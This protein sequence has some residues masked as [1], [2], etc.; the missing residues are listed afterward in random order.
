M[1]KL[2]EMKPRSIG[3][4][5]MSGRV[6]AIDAVYDQP[7]II[8]AGTASGGLWKS[9]SGGVGWKPVFD[10]VKSMSIGAVAI[11]QDNPEVVWAGTGE[12]NPRNSLNGGYG[13][14]KSL[15]GG[16]TWDL[17]GLEKTRHIHRIVIHP[18]NPDIVYVGAIG[19]PWGE[20]PER[21]VYKTTDGGKNWKKV[22]YVNEKTGAADLVIDP[23]NPNK[24]FAAMWEH[25]RK[26]WTFHSGGPGSGLYV[27]VDGGENWKKLT[28]EDG[29]PEGDLGR[30]GVA[31]S[32]SNP[33][34]VYALIESKK[35]ALYRS[36]D[37]GYKWQKINDNTNE[38]GNRPFYYSEI[39]VDPQNENRLYTI[40]T[41]V[42]ESEDGGKS[43][44]QLMP[45]YNTSRGVHPDHHAWWI[46]P[47]D[48]SYMIDGNDGGLNITHDRGQTWRFVENLPIAQ[49][50]HINVDMEYPYNVYG[51]M[52]DNGSWAGPAYVWKSQGIR[53]SYWQEISFGDGFDVIPDPDNSRYG[54]SMSQ[55]GFVV[56]YDKETGHQKFMRPTHPDPDMRLRFNWN[57]AIAQDPFDNSTLYF[58]SQFVHKS[59]DKG[60][61]WEVISPDLTTNDPEK[62][63]QDESG[64]LTIDATGAENNTTILAISPSPLQQGVIWVGTDDGFIQ[65]TRDG[66]KSWVNVTP[67]ITGMPK[68]GWVAQ[69]KPSTYN[70]GEAFAVV[71]NYRNSDYKPY[72]FHTTD[73]G[74]TWRS[75]VNESQVWN[76]TLS[77]VQDPV[78][79]KLMFLGSEGGLYVSID[80][81][82]N[83]TQWT[84]GY[85]M[86]PTM[87]LV[88]HPREH[89]L[90]IGTYGRAAYVLDDIRP[91]RA[92]AREGQ[93]VLN[94]QLELFKA[95]DAYLT[96]NQQP[97]GT[98]FSA[99]AIYSGENRKTG[100][101]I[102]YL[103][104][105]PEKKDKPKGEST[106]KKKGKQGNTKLVVEKPSEDSTKVAYD[107]LTLEVFDQ[108]GELLR[109]LK[110]KA[111]K[112]NGAHRMYWRLDEKGVYGPGRTKP[113]KNSPEPGGVSVLPGSYKLK[114]TFGEV[115]DST[116]VNVRFDPRVD[117]S[118]E[119]LKA[120]RAMLKQIE[121][122]QKLAGL[123]TARLVESKK[124]A[125][126]FIKKMNDKDMEAFKEAI[127][128]S[129]AAKD[130]IDALLVP[131]VGEDNSKKQ[132]IIRS[133]IPD[134]G[135]RFGTAS[136]Y[137]QSSLT[138][139]GD[140]EKMLIEQAETKLEVALKEVDSFFETEWENYKQ[141]MEKLDLSP[142]K[143]YEPLQK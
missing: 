108:K 112:E 97:S 130:S 16:K 58:G 94:K 41:Y 114:M 18:D 95:P 4:A 81:G 55:Q 33:K 124:I 61:T 100:A 116:T 121:K 44:T 62:Q 131:F 43:F 105:R 49:F 7:D 123:A 72:L 102:T 42:N 120:R 9:E 59:M 90:V 13:V 92:I 17:M 71:N 98:R 137:I 38:I 21:G 88:I 12:G 23:T 60:D 129:K 86:V 125:D 141:E 82:K 75:M 103:I 79:A 3:P 70:A 11:Q 83:W 139:P 110:R 47:N 142:F 68:A 104:N 109:T 119:V 51:G 1:D 135:D 80:G 140:T 54:Y 10:E 87:D 39:Y 29:L 40:F 66:G 8:Y 53:N 134:I 117:M 6:T 138:A 25:R 22:L 122:G 133:L 24:L 63:K 89:D 46:N 126:D 99:D 73:Y 101:M 93:R 118:V 128:R 48:P 27:T 31:V 84:N 136:Y 107:S 52:Q 106:V 85:P 111:P 57:A 77:F 34:R 15:D 74:N 26:P 20:H 65:I 14:Y 69:I 32:K 45:A 19:S 76:Y 50:Y 78:E 56:R 35:N 64:G 37:G 5:G 2:K 91:L 132:G 127:E 96:L 30:I 115:S 36:E 113:G 143:D 67:N 28:A